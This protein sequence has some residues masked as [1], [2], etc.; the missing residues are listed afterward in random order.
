M[1]KGKQV[2]CDNRTNDFQGFVLDDSPKTVEEQLEIIK[3]YLERS[4][5]RS[6][7]E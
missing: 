4:M 1:E 3:K 5:P 2:A 7:N 6:E